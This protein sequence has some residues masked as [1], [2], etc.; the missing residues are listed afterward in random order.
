M[1]HFTFCRLVCLRVHPTFDLLHPSESFIS[2]TSID[3]S[4]HEVFPE[5]GEQSFEG[6]LLP[7]GNGHF[8]LSFAL[9]ITA[10]INKIDDELFLSQVSGGSLI[11]VLDWRWSIDLT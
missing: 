2:F 4:T 7:N 10:N 8:I 1:V 3:G 5:S 11:N 6:D 9:F